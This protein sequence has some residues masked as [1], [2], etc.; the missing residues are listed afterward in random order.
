MNMLLEVSDLKLYYRTTKGVVKAV[1]R[2]NFGIERG[3]T[4][5]I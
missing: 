3:E 5:S 4:L 1:D 2:I